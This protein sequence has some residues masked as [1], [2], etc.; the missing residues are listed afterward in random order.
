[1]ET[2]IVSSSGQ[3]LMPI[4]EAVG[5]QVFTSHLLVVTNALAWRFESLRF[6]QYI[7][8]ISVNILVHRF[9]Q[10]NNIT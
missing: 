1:M 4:S 5:T 8:N 10:Q 9:R 2:H 3:V 7:T 6:H